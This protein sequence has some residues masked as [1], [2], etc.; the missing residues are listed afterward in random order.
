MR[1]PQPEHISLVLETK[2]TNVVKKR[3]YISF[4]NRVRGR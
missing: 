3:Q 1:R 4:T 2:Q